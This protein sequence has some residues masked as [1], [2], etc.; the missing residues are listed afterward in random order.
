MSEYWDIERGSS[1]CLRCM[2]RRPPRSGGA[3]DSRPARRPRSS[4]R[5]TA[6]CCPATGGSDSTFIPNLS[7]D[8]LLTARN[9]ASL[10]A[11]KNTKKKCKEVIKIHKHIH[12][13]RRQSPSFRCDVRLVDIC[14]IRVLKM[15]LGFNIYIY[16]YIYIY[17]FFNALMEDNN[18]TYRALDNSTTHV[19]LFIRYASLVQRTLPPS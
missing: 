3:G 9:A 17:I 4:Y 1:P 7:A 13:R 18:R 8:G 11:E 15:R 19:I 16:K 2:S 12:F 5:R 14:V 6:A 10:A